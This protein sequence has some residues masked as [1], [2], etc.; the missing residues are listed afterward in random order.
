[1]ESPHG[2]RRRNELVL[3][4]RKWTMSDQRT[5]LEWALTLE[6]SRDQIEVISM[7]FK[8]APDIMR[9]SNDFARLSDDLAGALYPSALDRLTGGLLAISG[10]KETIIWL[11]SNLVGEN[12]MQQKQR[13]FAELVQSDVDEAL[14]ILPQLGDMGGRSSNDLVSYKILAKHHPDKALVFLE[15]SPNLAKSALLASLGR[16]WVKTN[17]AAAFERIGQFES[18]TH[19]EKYQSG[20]I[21]G[22]V[23]ANHENPLLGLEN[24]ESSLNSSM[25]SELVDYWMKKHP[26]EVWKR[27]KEGYP[28][29]G[30]PPESSG[31]FLE[32]LT[33]TGKFSEAAEY[34]GSIEKTNVGKDAVGRL[35][36]LWAKHHV[37]DAAVWLGTLPKGELKDQGIL[38]LLPHVDDE[39]VALQWRSVMSNN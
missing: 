34:F 4:A 16:S 24:V 6:G 35:V 30:I 7:I 22:W 18:A 5:A 3:M 31:L 29:I 28:G 27:L 23:G 10:P 32:S 12:L 25:Q 20:L 8:S 19:N 21:K 13:V 26:A 39:E 9:L 38:K 1:M 33:R 14:E 37:E 11:N 36:D 17:P 2:T 15:R